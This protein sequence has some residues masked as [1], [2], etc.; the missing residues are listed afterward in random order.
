MRQSRSVSV[1]V[2]LLFVAA[3]VGAAMGMLSVQVKN[4]QL[5]PSPSFLASPAAPLAYGDQVELLQQQGDWME[6]NAPGGKKGWIHQSA[7]TQKRIVF[8]SGG[9]DAELSAS[10]E[11][12][13]LAGK[14]FNADVEARFKAS[15]KGIDFTWVDKMEQMKASPQELVA[16]LIAGGVQA[17]KGGVK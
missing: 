16:F 4:G 10:G 5:R 17:R 9:K 11:E 14:G 6:V 8:S 2:V 7:L 12:V 1:L 13:A 3:T 15:R